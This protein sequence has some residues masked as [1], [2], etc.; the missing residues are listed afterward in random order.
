MAHPELISKLKEGSGVW[1]E[2]FATIGKYRQIDL[3]GA[4]LRDVNLEG[5]DLTG[6]DIDRSDFGEANLKGANLSHTKLNHCV[7]EGANL[8]FARLKGAN[9]RD[10]ILTAADLTRAFLDESILVW[11]KL[12]SS[13][14]DG[15]I[16]RM[17]E[18]FSADISGATLQMARDFPLNDLVPTQFT[19]SNLTSANF[20]NTKLQGTDFKDANL[21][22]IKVQNTIFKEVVFGGT[23]IANIDLGG[24]I[25]LESCRHAYP[26]TIT[27]EVIKHSTGR[28]PREFLEGC[29]CSG[30]GI[31]AHRSS[32]E[33][34]GTNAADPKTHERI[35]LCHAKEDAEK[36]HDIYIRLKQAGFK[37]WLDKEDLLPGQDWDNQIRLAIKSSAYVLIFFSKISISKRVY[38]QKEFKLARDVLDEIPESQIFVIPVRL[39]DCKI[40]DRFAH[41]Q[42][43]NL[44]DDKGFE[45]MLQSI[46]KDQP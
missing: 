41:L 10:C 30:L 24:I 6:V 21:S 42:Y 28:I 4:D 37:P 34:K 15:A 20:E 33:E 35:F 17:A 40:P 39:E 46:S 43:C 5:V 25:G 23:I 27:Q 44:F 12:N 26:S 22:G 45:R 11:A 31:D 1:N 29:G 14:L 9:M 38:V 19:G 13:H 16:I 8:Q 18:L 32:D 2:W 36:V 3:I 7:L